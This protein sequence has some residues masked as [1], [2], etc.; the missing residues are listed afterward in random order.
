MA[1]KIELD[2]ISRR[3]AFRFLGL[4]AAVCVAVPATVLTVSDADAQTAGMERREDRRAGRQD[5]RDD[6]RTSRQDRRDDR[7]TGGSA[8]TGSNTGTK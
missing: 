1:D 5:R 2:L 4:T 6:R 7:R 3:S 8:T